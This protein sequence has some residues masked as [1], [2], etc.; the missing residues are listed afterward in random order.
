MPRRAATVTQADIARA[1]RAL[2]AAGVR[3]VRVVFRP[4][5]VSVEPAADEPLRAERPSEQV[6]EER[7]PWIM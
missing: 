3:D 7:E 1:V 2:R 5:G 4:E 6:A